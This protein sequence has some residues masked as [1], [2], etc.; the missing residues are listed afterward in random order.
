MTLAPAILDVETTLIAHGRA[1]RTRFWGFYDG[2]E[3]RQFRTT[4]EMVRYLV[5]Q[6]GGDPLLI[7]HHHDFDAIQIEHERRSLDPVDQA[8]FRIQRTRAG[9]VIRSKLGPHVLGNSYALFPSSLAALL[10]ATGT[11]EK[12][13]L[14]CPRHS[15]L[16]DHATSGMPGGALRFDRSF[17]RCRACQRALSDRN[18]SDCVQ[19]L[20]ALLALREKWIRIFDVD[21]FAHT[22]AAGV[23][24]AAAKKIAGPM[25]V[26][27]THR[28]AY[29]GGRTEAFHLGDVGIVDV[30]D[31]CSSYPASIAQAPDRDVL[32]RATVTVPKGTRIPPVFDASR[33]DGLFFP[34]G[35]VETWAYES[36]LVELGFPFKV[37]ERY[38]VDLS[39]LHTLGPSVDEWYTMKATSPPGDGY[40]I[41]ITI[42]GLYGRF[43]LRPEREIV[44][45][46]DKTPSGECT[47]YPI[48]TGGFLVFRQVV[49]KQHRANYPLASYTTDKARLRLYR[50]MV[51]V[52][53]LGG[54]VYY[55]DT[56]SI[57]GTRGIAPRDVGTGLGQWKP[58]V[59]GELRITS[60]KDYEFRHLPRCPCKECKGARRPKWKEKRK[61]GKRSTVWTIRRA[62]GG[63]GAQV[64]E[65]RRI[66]PYGKRMVHEDGTTD[67]WAAGEY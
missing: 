1:P 16:L 51:H 3:Y 29:R 65:K 23:A 2:E 12:L 18:R 55:C 9:R 4:R 24:M 32:M 64:I 28:E 34:V 14:S 22:T 52:E 8:A 39:W 27:T 54:A 40:S 5:R 46:E 42:N 17:D 44:K 66:T 36:T 57:M 47:Y 56:D 41:K 58:E 20:A 45:Y 49:S 31:V 33:T 19:G 62:L 15:D 26:D 53:H 13:P 10:E 48:A 63:K 38:P 21:P 60:V 25:P 37:R 7:F 11:G 67:A 59:P 6:R 61:G 50:G 43:G 30:H 35:N